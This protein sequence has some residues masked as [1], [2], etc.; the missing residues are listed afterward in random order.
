MMAKPDKADQTEHSHMSKSDK[1]DKS[2]NKPPIQKLKTSK[3]CDQEMNFHQ[4]CDLLV[5]LLYVF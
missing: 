3:R 5:L 2:S 4:G 1:S